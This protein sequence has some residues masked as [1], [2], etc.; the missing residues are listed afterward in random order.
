MVTYYKVCDAQGRTRHGTFKYNLGLGELTHDPEVT[1]AKPLTPC[2]RGLHFTT[3]EYI[4]KWISELGYT[5]VFTVKPVGMIKE[6]QDKV[7]CASLRTMGPLRSIHEFVNE[8]MCADQRMEMV[9][10]NGML[11][12]YIDDQ[13]PE[14]CLAAVRQNGWAL[15]YVREQTPDICL[16]AVR[17]DGLALRFVTHQTLEICMAA[18]KKDCRVYPYVEPSQYLKASQD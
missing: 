4:W 14:I 1:D 9:K 12:M 7:L 16:A 6:Y 18:V 17:R 13:T 3:W 5:H 11:L 2:R 8:D 15:E 10:Y